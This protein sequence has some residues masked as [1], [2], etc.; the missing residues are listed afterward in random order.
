MKNFSLSAFLDA[1]FYSFLTFAIGFFGFLKPFGRIASLYLSVFIALVVLTFFIYRGRKSAEKI[2]LTKKERLK[3]KRF[4]EFLC[5]LNKKDAFNVLTTAL[6]KKYPLGNTERFCFA[7]PEERARVFFF[8]SF[9]GLKK[10]DVVFAFNRLLPSEKA[11]IYSYNESAEVIEFSKRFLGRI[12]IK[13]GEE[14]YHLIKDF[15]PLSVL[16]RT[17]FSEKKKSIVFLY[18]KN[19]RKLFFFGAL[20]LIAS[21][22]VTFKTYYIIFGSLF[23]ICSAFSYFFGKTA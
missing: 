13:S 11:I 19:A 3:A 14:L 12:E 18:K 9:D 1:I 23:L 4:S 7:L 6:S 10:S 16:P 21:S 22:F 5:V 17:T 15:L 2:Y 20:F 8:F